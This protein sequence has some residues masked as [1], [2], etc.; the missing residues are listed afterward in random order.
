MTMACPPSRR[1]GRQRPYKGGVGSRPGG[2]MAA[3]WALRG[4]A[5]L[6]WVLLPSM[7]GAQQGAEKTIAV[8]VPAD[9]Q[10]FNPG[11]TT[12]SHTHAVADSLFNGLVALA[13]DAS[14]L[15]D[16]AQSW[17]IEDGGKVYRFK[18]A[19]NVQWHDGK[20]LTSADVA[21]TFREI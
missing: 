17:N 14:P 6:L 11:I 2:F 5:V 12:A 19:R 21:F 10:H 15:P 8:A 7:A 4:L 1:D 20:P 13:R 16:L 9:P 18:L 3:S